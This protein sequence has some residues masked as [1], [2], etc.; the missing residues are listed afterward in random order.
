MYPCSGSEFGIH[1]MHNGKHGKIY[2]IT[3]QEVIL[4]V[5]SCP[6]VD[7]YLVGLEVFSEISLK[8]S[9]RKNS[10]DSEFNTETQVNRVKV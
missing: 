5:L 7:V 6:L 2:F 9:F 4:Q 8:Y 10:S 1:K 3:L